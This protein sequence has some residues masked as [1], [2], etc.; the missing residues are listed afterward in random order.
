MLIIQNL[1]D[2]VKKSAENRRTIRTGLL[3]AI[4]SVEAGKSY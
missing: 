3:S 4:A 2:E 1:V